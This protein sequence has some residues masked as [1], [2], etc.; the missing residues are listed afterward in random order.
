MM[1]LREEWEDRKTRRKEENEEEKE[2]RGRGRRKKVKRV[3][4]RRESLAIGV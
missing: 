3:K 4:W 1:T 2:I